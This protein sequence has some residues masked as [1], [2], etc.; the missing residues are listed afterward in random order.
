MALGFIDV[1]YLFNLFIQR[2]VYVSELRRHIFMYCAFTDTEVG[3]ARP[4]GGTGINYIS[5]ENLASVYLKALP[6]VNYTPGIFRSY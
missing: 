1:Q 4:H 2:R 5:C 3:S 6:H